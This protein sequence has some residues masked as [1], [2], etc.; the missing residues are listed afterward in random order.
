[1][2]VPLEA[3]T[4]AGIEL[5]GRIAAIAPELREAADAAERNGTYADQSVQLLKAAGITAATV[6]E[7]LGGIGVDTAH[8]FAVGMNRIARADG[9]AALVDTMHAFTTFLFARAWRLLYGGEV[10]HGDPLAELLG[11]ISA[12]GVMIASLATEPGA[13]QTHPRTTAVREGDHWRVT[14]RKGFAT[15]SPSADLLGVVCSYENDAGER[16]RGIV[17]APADSPGIVHTDNWDSLGMRATGSQD[18]IFEDSV[19]EADMIDN[20][21]WGALDA[22]FVSGNSLAT[23]GLAASFLGIAEDAHD[24]AVETAST[25]R[26]TG[27]ATVQATVG[28]NECDLS[29]CRAMIERAARVVDEL[30]AQEVLA[31]SDDDA[32]LVMAEVQCAKQIVTHAAIRVVDRAMTVSGGSGYLATN[33]LSRLYRD[34][35]AGPFMQPFAPNDALAYV[36]QVALLDTPTLWSE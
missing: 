27:L 28:E 8:D 14:G 10:V 12:A 35:R 1:M 31:H 36:G 25:R 21:P 19:I 32:H 15:G 23:L 20:G 7:P 33:R 9:A 24:L 16:R 18:V 30:L 29:A 26:Q 13:H 3:R 6:P 22:D 34:V 2:T 17:F 4:P 11:R 5:L